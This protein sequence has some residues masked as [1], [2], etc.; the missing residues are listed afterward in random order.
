MLSQLPAYKILSE[1]SRIRVD[2]FWQRFCEGALGM[3]Y[4]L[5]HIVYAAHAAFPL[6]LSPELANLIWLNFRNY[7]YV[8]ED[9]PVQVNQVAVADS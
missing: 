8:D 5:G 1:D 2:A 7:R 6:M 9:D 4:G 3:Q